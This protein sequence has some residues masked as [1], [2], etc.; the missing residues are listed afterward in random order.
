MKK[1][2]L[3]TLMAFAG[4]SF[5]SLSPALAIAASPPSHF[6]VIPPGVDV[7]PDGA[8]S[9]DFSVTWSVTK[10]CFIISYRV[11]D[12]GYYYNDEFDQIPVQLESVTKVV[13]KRG[14]DFSESEIHTFSNPAPGSTVTYED[15]DV[16][17]GGTYNYSVQTFVGTNSNYALKENNCTA[18][19]LPA[20]VSDVKITTNAGDTPVT[21]T[22]RVPS[23]YSDGVTPLA[24]VDRVRVTM[25]EYDWISYETT[26]TEIG[27]V[28]NPAPGS[29][30]SV[31]Y[32]G[33]LSQGSYSWFFTVTAADGESTK[34]SASFYIGNDYP[35]KVENLKAEEQENG[36]ILVSWTA[37][38]AGGRGG[39]CDP[40]QLKYRVA[41]AASASDFAEE[42]VLV[43]DLETT[44]FRYK[45]SSKGQEQLS[46]RVTAV[47]SVGNGST[48][49]TP[50]MV[51]GPPL[52]LPFLELFDTGSG[53][54]WS[55]DNLWGET[56]TSTSS[57]PTR[58]SFS[59][60]V[61]FGNQELKPRSNEGGFA[62]IR[63]YST[64]EETENALVSGKI[65]VAGKSALKISYTYYQTTSDNT[66]EVGVD[67]SFD[68]ASYMQVS[69]SAIKGADAGWKDVT[70]NIEV[71]AG[72]STARVRIVATNGSKGETVVFDDLQIE[73]GESG[74]AVYPAP[75]SDFTS[76]MNDDGTAIEISFTAPTLSHH[77]LGEINDQPLDHIS[78]IELHRSIS[79]ADFT[80]IKS[81]VSPAPGSRITYSDTDLRKGGRYYYRA[82][83]YV[84]G[85]GEYGNYSDGEITV[86]ERPAD[87][88]EFT[89]TAPMGHAPVLISMQTP[90]TD[91]DG[92]PLTENIS[93][94][95][96]RYD[97]ADLA[98]KEVRGWSDVEPG[99]L[100][101]CT[102]TNPKEGEMYQYKAVCTGR[103]GDSYGV[104]VDLYVGNDMPMPPTDVKAELSDTGVRVTWTAPTQGYNN[105]YIDRAHLSYKVYRGT[106]YSDYDAT[107][108][109]S[110]L[111][112]CEYVD[113]YTF[114]DEM[115]VRY[116][117][118][119]VN[120]TLEGY[121]SSSNLVLVGNP[122]TLPYT[123]G[124]NS[125]S[126]GYIVADHGSWTMTSS[127]TNST[128]AFAEMA[129][130]TLEGQVVP[131]E[132]AG[133]AYSY[134]GIYNS[135]E[136][137]DYLTSGRID[138]TGAQEP[139]AS[140]FA[141]V[142]PD[143]ETTLSF[144]LVKADG[145]VVPLREIRF[146]NYDQAGW[147]PVTCDLTP[148]KNDG[149][150]RLC[151]HSHKGAYSTSAI[152]DY[153]RVDEKGS[154]IADVTGDGVMMTVTGRTLK[155]TAPNA[156]IELYT[157]DGRLVAT[158]EAEMTQT[159]APAIY[160]VKAGATTRKIRIK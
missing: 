128:W 75:V 15:H 133:L 101:E 105:G 65:N 43:P 85:R 14:G 107:E 57:Y 11:P 40:A 127:E 42:T 56:T 6:S 156:T 137:D 121:S 10:K 99:M 106:G 150:V 62:N 141:Y 36:D 79:D 13:L 34:H 44:S 46:F 80:L 60:Y 29:T 18:G 103:G 109:A 152:V 63:Y 74:P 48:A 67:I 51:V 142:V 37:P 12:T 118:K 151:F 53:Y 144:E 55:P 98:W 86:G 93:V 96:T 91:V 61:Y 17:V 31:V 88:T 76:R 145:S 116:F 143:Y 47:N 54:N 84:D 139:T 2:Y 108:I 59:N 159:L 123:E 30:Q 25:E 124:F 157:T 1:L 115:N 110:G 83:V 21:A 125:M 147:I 135:D 89:A 153:L 32:D 114:T 66:S 22:F 138:I 26:V 149:P 117:I 49:L 41:K 58:W 4:V 94:K 68:D 16:T 50:L 134:Y 28:E 27:V 140:F 7:Y 45:P 155:V 131:Y 104:T 102:D 148:Y 71:P 73:T 126:G 39:Y 160:I 97:A 132:G 100:L 19:S 38:S 81:F 90:E 146:D 72:A 23:V 64:G 82:I 122:S 35:G 95:L 129:Y 5:V 113:T 119:A 130:L 120:G 158:A 112:V 77:T 3:L 52:E 24:T 20:E 70:R 87:V 136:R 111:D 69:R 78:R 8:S 92:K 33:P 9:S 154:G